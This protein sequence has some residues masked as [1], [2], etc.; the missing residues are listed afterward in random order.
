MILPTQTFNVKAR[1]RKNH[2]ANNSIDGHD[3]VGMMHGLSL[4]VTWITTFIVDFYFW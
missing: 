3:I 1:M 4:N 2:F